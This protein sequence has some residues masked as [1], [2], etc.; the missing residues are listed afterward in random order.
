MV[1]F[2]RNPVYVQRN[3]MLSINMPIVEFWIQK[4]DFKRRVDAA[5]FANLHEVR[6]INNTFLLAVRN[7]PSQ[8]EI[9]EWQENLVFVEYLATN[10][11]N[12]PH[13]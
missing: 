6:S 12:Q 3:F 2:S 5:N 8:E 13:S 1:K 10:L 11:G 9:A 4:L 7:N